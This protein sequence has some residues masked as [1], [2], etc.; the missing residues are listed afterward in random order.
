MNCPACRAARCR[1][2]RRRTLLDYVAALVG[3]LPWRCSCCG[4]RFRARVQPASGLFYAHCSICGNQELKRIAPE[5]VNGVFALF[6]KA[7]GV[8]AFRCVPCRHKFFSLRPLSKEAQD[9]QIKIAS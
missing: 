9:D 8:P 2:S 1:R 4:T 3:S 7:L 6:W 5:Y